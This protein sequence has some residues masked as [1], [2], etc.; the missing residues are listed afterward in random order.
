MAARVEQRRN[1]AS[2]ADRDVVM[3]QVQAA[4]APPQAWTHVDARS[5]IQETLARARSA[6]HLSQ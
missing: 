4:A 2:D 6:L 3:R 5:G 1:D